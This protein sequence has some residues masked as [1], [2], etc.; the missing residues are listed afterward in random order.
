MTIR[1]FKRIRFGTYNVCTMRE[2]VRLAQVCKEFKRYKFGFL[3]LCEVRRTGAGESRTPSGETL[4]HSGMADEHH[5]GVALL[6]SAES[7]RSLLDWKPVNERI[8][9]ARF[10]SYP[11]NVTIVQVYAP[12]NDANRVEESEE[13]YDRLSA[14]LDEVPRADIVILMGD[15]NAKVGDDNTGWET[16]MGRHGLGRM[17]ENG[18]RLAELCVKYDLVI[19]GTLFPHKVFHKYTWTKR[20]GLAQLSQVLVQNQIDHIAVSRKWRSSLEDVRNRRGADVASDH[21]LL[22]GWM[23]L[24]MYRGR[25]AATSCNAR[26]HNTDVL[27]NPA[28]ALRFKER[29]QE[30]LTAIGEDL[31]AEAKWKE[32]QIAYNSTGTEIL[33]TKPIDRK[34]WISDQTWK[35]IE[36]RRVLKRMELSATDLQQRQAATEAYRA[37]HR[38]VGRNAR[39]DKRCWL[40]KLADEAQKAASCQNMRETYRI[41]K[42]LCAK[43]SQSGHLVRSTD[44]RLL[45][46]VEDQADRWSE[47]FEE[48]LN[49]APSILP[50]SPIDAPPHR[51]FNSNPPTRREIADAIKRLKNNKA[52]GL[53]N[54]A[55]ELLK[56]DTDSISSQLELIIQH[57]WTI[58]S[59]PT[60]WKTGKIIKLPKKGNLTQC[61]NW[62]GITLLNTVN[63]VL[64]T[65]LYDRLSSVLDSTLR[66]EQAGFRPGRSCTDHINTL[67]I[68]VEQS[69]EWQSP[70]HLLFVDF[71]RAF[72]SLDRNMMWNVLASYGVPEKLLAII[73]SMYRD[74]TCRVAHRGQLGREFNVASGVKQGCILSPLLFLLV[75]DWVMSKVNN[76]PRGIAWQ[77]LRMTRLED[78]AFADDICLLSHTRQELAEKLNRLVHYGK[79]VG[80]KVNVSKTKLMRLNT[81]TN[82]SPLLIDGETID[83]VE[84]FCYLGCIIAKD[85]G[86][87]M[88]V[89]NRIMKARQAYGMLNGFWRSN[90]IS[91]NLKLR[92]FRSNVLSVLLY[93]SETW[94]STP[95]ITHSLQVFINQ[96][97]RR[98][99]RIRWPNRISNDELWLHTNMERVDLIIFRRKWVWIGHTLRKRNDIAT[100][101]LDW[102]PPGRRRRGRPKDT[103]RRSIEREAAAADTT[104]LQLKT[105]AQNRVRFRSF[106]SALCASMA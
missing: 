17:N 4:L 45:T 104:W 80:L 49:K 47:Y 37:K 31:S 57:V 100:E 18:R 51:N 50:R 91:L 43:G 6:L 94:K 15:L 1:N 76:S 44:G 2:D 26:R 103:W 52:P 11:K 72:D 21:E 41:A 63:K 23:R 96:C 22:E 73:Q 82:L 87:G 33:G 86:A 12:T 95:S 83:E 71:E 48:V 62:R 29:M 8:I 30:K 32:I 68:I 35:M 9:T 89:D 75:L 25:R 105:L 38:E 27:K 61:T 66:R 97:L 102:N 70:L 101:A 40:N 10:S 56:V 20:P 93:G 13:F 60:E 67:R 36:D 28:V 14:T 74:A 85:G 69:N 46:N 78:L 34:E 3:G 98:I 5:R 19:G 81:G 42:Q 65:V 53:D 79:Q 77:H 39:N 24:K 7:R 58:E 92:F 88:C 59:V 54:I 64:S 106:V 99:L 55:S 84:S 90:Q 16:V